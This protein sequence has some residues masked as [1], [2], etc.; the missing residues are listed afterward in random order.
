LVPGEV[1]NPRW[2]D[3]MTLTWD[4]EPGATEYNVYRDDPV[5]LAYSH[6]GACRNDLDADR[7]DTTLVDAE[8]PATGAAFFYLITSEGGGEEG[9]LGD[10]SYTERSNFNPC[11]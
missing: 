2:T 7:T 4:A 6:F 1:A 9:T 8:V 3:A 5:N 11:M 10:A